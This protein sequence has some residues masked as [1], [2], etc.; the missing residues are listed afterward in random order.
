MKENMQERQ[1]E[2]RNE[3]GKKGGRGT[4][5]MEGEGREGG[6]EAERNKEFRGMRM[7]LKLF[8]SELTS[9]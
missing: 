5:C 2:K 6:R 1:K 9:R 3:R 7:H 8:R 4:V